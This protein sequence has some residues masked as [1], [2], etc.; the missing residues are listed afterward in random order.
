MPETA[1]RDCVDPCNTACWWVR[2]LKRGGAAA[3]KGRDHHEDQGNAWRAHRAR[4]RLL[5]VRTK[6][7][8]A[9]HPA[10]AD[11]RATGGRSRS[12]D[13]DRLPFPTSQ[14]DGGGCWYGS[15][16]RS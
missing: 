11:E 3:S 15:A 9:L 6:R 1:A 8:P 16:K 7:V 2:S 4:A 10:A 5:P 12:V 14:V 13:R